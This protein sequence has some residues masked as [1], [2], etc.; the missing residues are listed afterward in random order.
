MY[1]YTAYG[2]GI[3]STLPLPEFIASKVDKDVIIRLEGA[4][5]I[6]TEVLG[7]HSYLN[8]GINEAIL[9]LDSL[10]TFL[11]RHGREIIVIPEASTDVRLIRRYLT[12]TIMAILLYQRGFVVLHASA[13]RVNS[14][15]ITFVGASGSG[16]STL[17]AA[18]LKR[19]YDLLTD[20]IAAV[21]INAS[22]AIVNPGFPQIKINYETAQSL[23]FKVESLFSLTESEE[24]RGYRVQQEFIKVPL[25]LKLIYILA[26][27]KEDQ[28]RQ[29]KSQ[30]AVI[31]LIRHS[32]PT[33]LTQQGEPKHLLNCVKLANQVPIYRLQRSFSTPGLLDLTQI[34]EEHFI[35]TIH[36]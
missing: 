36:A 15:A 35:D 31:E 3:H 23:G 8:I 14:G 29:L 2:L 25:P 34:V 28:I 30:E 21:N 11:V 10:G 33:R 32:Y 5:H 17:V 24:K 19:G 12:G 9:S 13:I 16:K 1:T 4:D 22:V 26:L 7:T 18:L 27:G 6:P 20:D